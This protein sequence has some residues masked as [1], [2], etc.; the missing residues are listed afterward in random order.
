M[1]YSL[2]K[3]KIIRYILLMNVNENNKIL[4]INEIK[5]L[6]NVKS[7]KNKKKLHSFHYLKI[8]F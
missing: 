4:I 2:A 5:L 8:A 7:K 6:I 1:I 3:I